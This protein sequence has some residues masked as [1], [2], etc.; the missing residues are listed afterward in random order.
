[1]AIGVVPRV[2]RTL[3]LVLAGLFVAVLAGAAFAPLAQAS[4]STESIRGTLEE[5]TADDER[6]PVPGV[7]IAIE[8]EGFEGEG[9]TDENG[10]WLVELP[11]P[12]SYTAALDEST[13]PDEVVLR[14]AEDN[15]WSGEVRTG[16][17]QV[18]RFNLGE[19][20]ARSA[21]TLDRILERGSVGLRFGLLLA[22]AAVGL[23]L[24]FG[25]T[26]LTN[27]AHAEQVT[28][29]GL[30]GYT[31]AAG[32]GVPLVLAAVMVLIAGA[33]FGWTQDAALWKPLRRRGTGIIPMMIVTIGLSLFARSVVQAFYGSSPRSFPHRSPV[34]DLGPTR[35]TVYDYVTMGVAA[36]LLVAV[37][38]VLLRT[39][40]GK[41]TRAVSDNPALA[42]ASGINVDAVVRGVWTVGAALAA[43]GGMFLGLSQQVS[44][45]MGVNMLLLMFAAVVLGGLGT[46]FGAMAGAL[47]V[48]VFIEVSTIV[49]P[50]EIKNVGALAILILILLVRPQGMLGRR[51][52]VG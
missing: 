37:A 50:T 40:W 51:E 32:M 12:G 36:A 7:R 13:L 39:R 17:S 4:G 11:G 19:G 9:V 35:L 24:I 2:A 45:Q 47:I 5:R 1:M 38:Y 23:S 18:V 31:F 52:R 33:L 16:R 3:A 29:G 28:L 34:V 10:D 26:G 15:P 22:L 43:L 20:V 42:A 44:A 6:I 14:D 30:L 8:G 27:F 49:I 21:S 41:A 48:G 25:T 46:A